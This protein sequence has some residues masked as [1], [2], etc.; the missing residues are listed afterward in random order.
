MSLANQIDERLW[1]AVQSAYTNGD[2]TAAILDSVYFLGDVIRDRTGLDADG[3]ALVGAAVG[4]TS[5]K[6]K[7]NNLETESDRNVQ[8]GVEQLLRGFYQA[9]RNPRSHKKHTD[10]AQDANAVIIFVDFLVRIIDS[11]KAEFVKSEFVALVFDDDFVET[12]RYA[13]LLVA[14]VPREKRLDVFIEIYRRKTKGHGQKI[15]YFVRNLLA[16]LDD[17]ERDR[18]LTIVESELLS[19]TDSTVI[20]LAIQ[21]I[22]SEYW[23][24]FDEAVRLRVENKLIKSV[25]SGYY[26][27]DNERC[28]RGGLGTWCSSLL[29]HLLS[30]RELASA[31]LNKLASDDPGESDYAFKY[32]FDFLAEL[33]PEPSP[34]AV[35]TLEQG[36]A[37][38][39]VRFKKAL[40]SAMTF[41]PEAWKQ[42]LEV[43]YNNFVEEAE[44]SLVSDDDVPF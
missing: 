21:M 33:Q 22:P 39:D 32:L 43:P 5:P 20:R 30:R 38:G 27:E 10:T 25:E 9:I 29:P 23:I 18:A 37:I 2:Y 19:T 26:D 11:A 36:L 16:V 35:L 12:D 44:T 14:K 4:G 3:V 24:R 28:V 13:K 7:A 41:G 34:Y 40:A 15:G 1:Q 8:R 17:E 42:R 6:L 31:I